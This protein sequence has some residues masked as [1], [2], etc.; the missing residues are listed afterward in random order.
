MSWLGYANE[1]LLVNQWDDIEFISC[2]NIT[3]SICR[4]NN[5]TDVL[6]VT[7]MNEDHF[8]L[9]LYLMGALYITFRIFTYGFLCLKSNRHK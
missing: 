1:V 8:Y 3:D 9:D 6:N 4:Y 2:N 7:G 5:G